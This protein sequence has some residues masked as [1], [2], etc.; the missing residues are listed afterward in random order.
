[1][2]LEKTNMAKNKILLNIYK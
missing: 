2:I 1:M